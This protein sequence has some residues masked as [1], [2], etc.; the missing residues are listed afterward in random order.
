MRVLATDTATGRTRTMTTRLVALQPSPSDLVDAGFVLALVV[1]ALLGFATTFDS[2]RY[3][4]VGLVGTVLGILLAHVCAV[5][6]WHWTV[7]LAAA[8]VGYLLLGGLFALPE[9]LLAGFLPTP[10]VFGQLL[11]LVVDGWKDML[12]LLPPLAGDGPY[13]AL[14]YLLGL[15][16][17]AG[18]FT[19]ARR[20]RTPWTAVLVP[21]VLLAGVILLGTYEPAAL[22]PQGL[23]FAALAFGWT[24]IRAQR[25]RRLVGTGSANLTRMVLGAVVL[26]L[27]LAGGW[28]LGP[29]FA[30]GNATR[31]VLRS[32]VEPPVELPSYTSP[33][34]G[35]PKY[36]TT[37]PEKRYH[38]EELLRVT[39]STPV[40]WLR[41]AVLDDYSG[42]TWNAISG[43]EGAATTAFQRIGRTIP[44]PPTTDLVDLT[45]TIGESYATIPELQAWLPGTGRASRIEFVGDDAAAH[46]RSLRYNLSTGQAMVPDALRPGDVI[47]ETAEAPRVIEPGQEL[48]PGGSPI[49][50]EAGYGFLQAGFAKLVGDQTA[51][52]GVQLQTAMDVMRRNYFSDGTATSGERYYY[53]PGHDQGR[54]GT[55]VGRFVENGQLVGSDEH[56]ASTLAL[57]ANSLGFPA[58]VVFGAQV[59]ADGVVRGGDVHAWVELQLADGAWWAVPPEQF[60]PTQTPDQIKPPEQQDEATTPVPPPAPVRPPGAFDSWFEVDTSKLASEGTLGQVLAVLL[61]VLRLAGPPLG[62]V[63]LLVGGII[64]AKAV[65][66]RRRRTRGPASTRIA[67]GWRELLDRARDLGHRV[68][69]DATRLEQSL[70][71]GR[72]DLADISGRADRV[73][74]GPGE[75]GH[76]TAAEFWGQVGATHKG[77][78]S[79]LSWWRRWLARLSLR[80]FLPAR[81]GAA[82][83]APSRLPWRLPSPGGAE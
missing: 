36:S 18:G 14:V 72:A 15:L 73:I 32:W 53:P 20:S 47:E 22:L 49:V 6:R 45:I 61:L 65:R 83:S 78:L 56:Y 48:S 82:R 40:R 7:P 50:G 26:A 80:S 55:F 70:V 1:L 38:D 71:V 68:P 42:I 79:G 37:E 21:G 41:L 75:P 23:G 64:G 62:A 10:A 17:G 24:A 77:M 19:V 43:G 30:S 81:G 5:L 28:A 58:R 44:D 12:T 2:A 4:M 3:L 11:G 29:Q 59:P 27:A 25:R 46:R 16:G 74:F 34:V 9:A 63:A 54:L 51:P 66:R 39:S 35:F 67:A 8:V 13:V 76:E 60:L 52:A 31:L 69:L 33:L 57:L